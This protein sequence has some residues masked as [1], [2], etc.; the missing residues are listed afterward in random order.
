MSRVALP[1]IVSTI[2]ITLLSGGTG[3]SQT[4]F[5]SSAYERRKALDE[6]DANEHVKKEILDEKILRETQAIAEKRASCVKQAKEHGLSF[7]NR[8]RFLKRCMSH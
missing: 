1:L 4:S 8:R 3:F 6:R 7:Y 5:A 2:V